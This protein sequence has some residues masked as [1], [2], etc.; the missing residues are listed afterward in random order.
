MKIGIIAGSR[1]LPLVLAQRIKEVNSDCSLIAFCFK[2]ET[3]FSIRRYVDKIYWIKIGQ[4]KKLKHILKKEDLKQCIMAG[5][6]NPLRIFKRRDW[7]EELISLIDKLKDFRSHTIFSKI[8]DYLEKEGIVFSNFTVYLAKDLAE[9]GVMNGLSL[10]E[11]LKKDIDFGLKIISDFV[12]LDVGQT[13]AVKQGSVVGLESLEGTDRTIKRAYRLAGKG[14]TI[15]KF[16]KVN[17]DLRFDL[18]VVG[19]STLKLLRHIKAASLVLEEGKVIILEKDKFLSLAKK[20]RIPV[21]GRKKHEVN[22]IS[23]GR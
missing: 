10:N 20:W 11:D 17:Q 6:I 9:E 19:I 3:S 12:E 5:Q 1:Q 18:P 2:G 15:L 23:K 16:S 7:D 8:I 14:C 22:E 13:I 4:L 21:V